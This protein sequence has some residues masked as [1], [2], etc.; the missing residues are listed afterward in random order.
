MSSMR[1]VKRDVLKH[2]IQRGGQWLKFREAGKDSA[3]ADVAVKNEGGTL[4]NL[5]RVEFGGA[6]PY[7][8]FRRRRLRAFKQFF[9]IEAAS[10]RTD[11]RRY[12]PIAHLFSFA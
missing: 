3:I 5:E 11:L 7:R 6:R 1:L 12:L 9:G 8:R 4:C 2:G 10:F